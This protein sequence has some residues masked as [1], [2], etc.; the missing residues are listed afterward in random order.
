ML[1]ICASL[2]GSAAALVVVGGVDLAILVALA[3]RGGR[4]ITQ[5]LLDNTVVATYVGIGVIESLLSDVVG[6]R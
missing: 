5:L 1:P 3:Q 6:I 4:C 2:V